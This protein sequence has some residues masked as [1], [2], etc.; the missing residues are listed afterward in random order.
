MGVLY[1]A[2]NNELAAP[3]D[4]ITGAAFID[5]RPLTVLLAS[6][7]AE[8]IMELNGQTTVML[9]A[10]SAAF[11]GTLVMEVTVD[12]ANWFPVPMTNINS[13]ATSLSAVLSGASANQFVAHVGGF[14]AVKT[15]VS[16]YTSGNIDVG[17]RGTVA[18][19]RPSLE[20]PYPTTLWVTATAAANAAATASLPAAGAG[21][22]HYIT[23]IDITRN[24]TAILAGG[25]TLIHT[26]TNLPG[27]PAWSVGNNMVAG[28]TEKDVSI[29]F[30]QPLKSL[31]ANTATTVVAAAAGLAVLGRVN[32]GYFV[33][34]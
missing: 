11:S 18:P 22:Y 20:R 32:V 31:A 14:F 26:T 2:R 15:R 33:G 6:L 7:N 23:H 29:D 27:S 16:A 5:T 1:D 28:G 13:Q 10:R 24:A 21:L 30:A 8:T 25:A 34:A 3:L 4:L 9:D 17:M 12:G 19:L